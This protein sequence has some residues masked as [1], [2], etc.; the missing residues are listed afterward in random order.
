MAN[1]R[2]Y[3][4][5]REQDAGQQTDKS[6]EKDSFKKKLWLHRGRKVLSVVCVIAL[7]VGLVFGYQYYRKNLVYTDYDVLAVSELTETTNGEYKAYGDYILRYS[8]D[9]ISCMDKGGAL[10]WGQ[11][12]EIKNPIVEVCG[13]YVAVAAL[14]GNEVYIFNKSG[15]QGELKTQYPINAICVAGQGVVAVLLE[16]S[17]ENYIKM[18]DV[19]GT[20]LVVMKTLLEGEGYPFAM[21]LSEDG[22]KMAV[23][24]LNIVDNAIQNTV[25]F[26]NFS[27]VGQNYVEQLVGTYIDE[28][29]NSLVPDIQFVNN[30]T[31][32]AFADNQLVL[33]KM[34]EIPELLA[35]VPI[36][37]KIHSVFYNKEYIGLITEDADDGVLQQLQVYKVSDG[38][39]VTGITGKKLSQEY[40]NAFFADENLVLYNQSS[41]EI[42]TLEGMEKFNY[43][44][45]KGI[46]LFKHIAD[47]R[48]NLITP[49]SISE[50]RLK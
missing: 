49:S 33:F 28:F 11:A 26:Y 7:L 25:E 1:I 35:Q 44:F 8:M 22:K 50:I 27:E 6:G 36:E 34:K 21:A 46:M 43:S 38:S 13:D 16:D 19:F 40:R 15:Y 39:P 45:E 4:K 2:E 10:V 5:K 20:E 42:I 31:V 12:Y 3:M 30:N 23:S 47:T 32:C 14:K 9:G 29:E 18:Y 24:Y 48:Y 41:C 17:G 37:E